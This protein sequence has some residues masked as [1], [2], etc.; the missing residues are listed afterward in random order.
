MT[1]TPTASQL[2]TAV[3]SSGDAVAEQE[4]TK[5][6]HGKKKQ[7][8]ETNFFAKVVSKD[9]ALHGE[10]V[11]NYVNFFKADRERAERGEDARE[12]RSER[13]GNY[14]RLTNTYY[15]LVTDLY[16]YGWGQSFHFARSYPGESFRQ[17]IARHEHYLAHRL[18]L[19]PGMKV[20]DVGCGVGG[21][22][23]EMIHF[24][25]VNV[26]GLNNNEYQLERAAVYAAR[27]KI[28]NKWSSVKGDFMKMD[29]PD[30]SFDA[31]YAIEATVHAPELSGVYGEI[32][33]VLKPGCRFACY[34]WCMTDRYDDSNPEHRRIRL[35]IEE[36]NG[37]PQMV[38]TA[39][40]LA[41]LRQVGFNVEYH[42]AVGANDPVPWYTPLEGNWT[43]GFALTSVGV[44]LT[45]ALCFVMEKLGMAPAGTRQVSQMLLDARSYLVAGAKLGIFTPMFCFVARKPEA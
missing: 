11:E 25:D 5:V 12:E 22:A 15:N 13:M 18:G 21:P 39:D 37:I 27:E 19:Q 32:F 1:P 43:R 44:H 23:R 29:I 40:A 33:R 45:D 36:G 4:Y 28:S 7:T 9:R 8:E 26:T 14:A 10:A 35:G 20:L 30:N 24:A 38:G 3:L 16:E 42:E 34:E 2:S 41:A 31:V 17:S 6:L